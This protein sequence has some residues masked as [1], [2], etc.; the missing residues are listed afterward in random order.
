L[1]GFCSISRCALG[2]PALMLQAISLLTRALLGLRTRA[3]GIRLLLSASLFV[4]A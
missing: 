4:F 1:G 3:S 2:A